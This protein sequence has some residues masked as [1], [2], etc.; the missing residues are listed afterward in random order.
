[1]APEQIRVLPIGEAHVDR[2][3]EVL[4]DLRKSGLRVGTDLGPNRIGKKVREATV[5]KVPYMAVIGDSEVAS[6][7]VALRHR[8]LR[9]IGSFSL[10]GLKERLR[11]EVAAR[12]R[13]AQASHTDGEDV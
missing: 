5:A 9:D 8:K 7:Q 6:G 10:D 13:G 1:L 11:A 4:E 12:A 2:A 3:R